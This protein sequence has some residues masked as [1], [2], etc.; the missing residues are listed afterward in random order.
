MTTMM[1][2]RCGRWLRTA[3]LLALAALCGTASARAADEAEADAVKGQ[4]VTVLK[5]TKACFPAM[6][7]VSG[8]VIPRDEVSVRPD[9]PGA[10]VTEVLAE[11]GETVTQGQPLAKLAADAGG[12]TV[13]APV[14]GLVSSSTAAIG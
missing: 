11:P 10:K 3:S 14:A 8:F 5:A 1:A 9:R 2:N 7:D 6:V 4:A 13:Q 12:A